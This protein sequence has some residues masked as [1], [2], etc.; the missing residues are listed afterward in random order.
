L[1]KITLEIIDI[2]AKKGGMASYH[3][4]YIP[5]VRSGHTLT[6]QSLEQTVKTL[7][8]ADCAVIATNHSVFDAPFIRKH[9]KLTVDMRNMIKEAS[10]KVYKL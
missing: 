8:E 3:N 2:V 9:A 1:L 4:P 7:K 10:E 6:I 5:S